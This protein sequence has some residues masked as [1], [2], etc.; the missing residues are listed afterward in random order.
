LIVWLAAGLLA[1]SI[2]AAIAAPPHLKLAKPIQPPQAVKASSAE[3][4]SYPRQ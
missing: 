4:E 1:A 3:S 2:A